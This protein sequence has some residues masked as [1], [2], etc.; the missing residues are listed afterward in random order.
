[1]TQNSSYTMFLYHL[2]RCVVFSVLKNTA[3]SPMGVQY[4]HH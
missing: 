2:S 4:T 1:M 3:M